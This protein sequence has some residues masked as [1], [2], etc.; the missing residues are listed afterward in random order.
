[1]KNK[2]L[3]LNNG[4]KIPNLGL[5]TWGSDRGEVGQ[6]VE[7]AL[8]IGY[9]HID[10]ASFYGNEKE[11]G[12]AFH[13]IFTGG[14]IK[15]KD[16]FVTSKLW[17]TDHNPNNVIKAY[18]KTLSD[19]RLDYLDLYLIHWGIA[20][21]PGKDLVPLDKYGMVITDSVS[22]Q[23][24]WRAM[25][26]LIDKGLVKS[27]G[28]ANFTTAMLVDLLSYAKIKPVINQIEIHPYNTQLELVDYCYK[29]HIAVTGYSP[30]G[31][32]GDAKN[33]P[34][35]DKV[36][37]SIAKK[38]D[39]SPAQVLIRWSLQRGLIVIPK[40]TSE[41]RIKENFNVFDF[42]LTETE[43]SNISQLNK[44]HRYVNPVEWGVP[45]FK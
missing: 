9:R 34:I 37:I 15:R 38:H 36:I 31:S 35:S 23:E 28:V 42:E 33:K 26:S 21:K 14:N 32:S 22:M 19:L 1:M 25:E 8:N 17:N 29:K 39:V 2:F 43:I 20:F 11:I 7:R 12:K 10:C 6:A 3:T 18:K 24:T 4:R 27:I 13:T 40:T 44:N 30:L 5:G 16:V 41:I 45:Y